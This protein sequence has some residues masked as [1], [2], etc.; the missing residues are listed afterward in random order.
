MQTLF[1]M[2]GLPGAGKTTAA[3]EI[4]KQTHAVH[5]SSDDERRKL[6]KKSNFTQDE[7]TELYQHIEKNVEKLLSEGKS[8]IYDANLNR[9]EHRIE[10]YTLASKFNLKT[11]LIWVQTPKELAKKRRVQHEPQPDLTPQDE[12]PESMFD[13]IAGVFEAPLPAN[14]EFVIIDGQ[15][16]NAESIRVMLSHI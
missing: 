12:S 8:V 15:H 1:L 13:R 11:I 14:E 9:L 7:H 6:F 16:V 3:S 5:I 4:A 10:K 2:L